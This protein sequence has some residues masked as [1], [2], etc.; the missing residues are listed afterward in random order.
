[1]VTDLIMETDR[2]PGGPGCTLTDS[3]QALLHRGDALNYEQM[4]GEFTHR[5]PGSAVLRLVKD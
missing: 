1:M 3:G 4:F 5:E 2:R